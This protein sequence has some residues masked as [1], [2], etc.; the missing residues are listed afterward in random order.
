MI[1]V[2]DRYQHP[3]S[4]VIRS[5]LDGD[6]VAFPYLDAI[7]RY[8]GGALDDAE[9]DIENAFEWSVR[10]G[11]PLSVGRLPDLD[12]TDAMI[13]SGEI[14]IVA[15]G[16]DSLEEFSAYR[17]YQECDPRLV[18]P[19]G[20]PSTSDL[21]LRAERGS[22]ARER[23]NGYLK[24]PAVG[25]Q[26]DPQTKP[27]RIALTATYRSQE[28][29]MAVLGRP[30]GRHNADGR[31]IEL[32]RF[33]AHPDRPANTG[34][35]LLARCCAWSRLEGYDRLLTY[36]GVQ[37]GNE[38][39]MYQAAGF[40]LVDTV[41]ADRS[42]WHSRDGRTGGGTYRKRR[43]Q[44]NL[45]THLLEA[46]RPAGRVDSGQ[47][48]LTNRGTATEPACASP[49]SVAQGELI[50]TR[51]EHLGRR[52]ATLSD[53]VRTFLDEQK[54]G[55][56]GDRATNDQA[57]P[58]VACFAYRTP[59]NALVAVLCLCDHSE[60]QNPRD[61]TNTV[62]LSTVVV[63]TNALAYPVNVTRSLI[64]KVCEWARLHGYATVENRLA[65]PVAT[66]ATNGITG[67]ESDSD[68]VAKTLDFSTT[69]T[70][71]SA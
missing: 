67:L 7:G 29:A 44:R 26:H 5:L 16:F 70:T 54:D 12:E 13:D 3:Q 30:S 71:S 14:V 57:P 66:D 33:A 51:E 9:T 49:S 42:D 23:V 47:T 20:A 37:N 2:N 43:Y 15:T 35:W 34:S 22:G 27:F 53:D 69:R 8:A 39:T 65:R 10:P 50:Q 58:L 28:V 36:A 63:Q 1:P 38:G 41:V 64:A 4:R 19:S 55:T 24:H 60:E 59:E 25:Y 17:A 21:S 32:Y 11:G 52:G 61:N 18:S 48:R 45:A 62:T 68:S 56:E 46:R 31:T 40:E 6:I